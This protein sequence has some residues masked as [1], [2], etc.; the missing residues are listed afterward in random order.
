L[1]DAVNLAPGP[2]KLHTG[3]S[4]WLPKHGGLSNGA[5]YGKKIAEIKAM[6]TSKNSRQLNDNNLGE[7]DGRQILL[8]LIGK[9]TL[10][11]RLLRSSTKKLVIVN[12]P[13]FYVQPIAK[14]G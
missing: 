14:E 13:L 9:I 7:K 6:F 11:R 2:V 10:V 12:T 5:S 3:L 8:N 1:S 4:G